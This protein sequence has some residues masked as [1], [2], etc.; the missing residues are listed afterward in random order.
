[1]KVRVADLRPNPFRHLDR[2]PVKP[3]KVEALKA[4]IE[5]TS[6]WDNLVARKSPNSDG[7]FEIAYGHN[8]LQA[9]RDL[10]VAEID[11]AIRDL[12][13]NKM[14]K[15]MV[16]ENQEE[17]GHSSEGACEAVRA[18]VEAYGAGQI[19]LG[20][21]PGRTNETVLRYAPNF[22]KGADPDTCR[23]HPYT[24][25][26]LHKFIGWRE[27]YKVETALAALEL[28]ESN[29][30]PEHTFDGLTTKQA[31]AVVTQTRRALKEK[32]EKAKDVA[33]HIANGF[34]EGGNT[35]ARRGKKGVSAVTIHT[36]K[37]E[38]DKIIGKPRRSNAN[39]RKSKPTLN[40]FTEKLSARVEQ[41][42]SSTLAK[43]IAEVVKFHDD[44]EVRPRQLL[45]RA[46][47]KVEKQMGMWADKLDSGQKKLERR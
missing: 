47:R 33:E 42:V 14:A 41:L 7:G 13:N 10:R 16:R 8:R 37:D 12:D 46:L 4:S 23:D 43:Q 39:K 45:L 34:R 2:D 18:I 20:K 30:L 26:T 24:V 19:E 1:M 25:E 27:T 9:L 15:I 22:T 36:A 40:K 28:I 17:W 6:F 35:K 38:A 29:K 3:D 31:Q 32:P 5:E 21:P 11:I 44:L